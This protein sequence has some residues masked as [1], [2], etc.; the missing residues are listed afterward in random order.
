MNG[1]QAYLA[2]VGREL[3][4]PRKQ[5]TVALARIFSKHTL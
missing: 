2:A 5:K 4:C 1:S 3:H